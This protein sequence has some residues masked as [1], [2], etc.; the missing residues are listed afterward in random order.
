MKRIPILVTLLTLLGTLLVPAAATAQQWDPC[1]DYADSGTVPGGYD[2]VIG[3]NGDTGSQFIVGDGG[4]NR[5]RGK[6][7]HDILCGFGGNDT[8]VG[9]SGHD[10]VGGGAGND[11][12][13]GNSGNEWNDLMTPLIYLNTPDRYTL[14]IGLSSLKTDY[15]ALG[16]QWS[17]LMAASVIFTIPMIILFF[18]FQRSFMEGITHSGVKG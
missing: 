16:T 7:G 11:V 4:A 9:G 3:G 18:I 10:F 13:R 2:L 5:L 17:L 12:L 15:Q 8:L 6:S 1:G 14:A